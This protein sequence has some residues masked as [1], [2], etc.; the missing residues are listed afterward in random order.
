MDMYETV[1]LV[2]AVLGGISEALSLI[3][4]VKANGVFQ[5]V[6]NVLK[7]AKEKLK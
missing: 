1:L 7:A 5:L 4:Q 6:A 2:I 3:P